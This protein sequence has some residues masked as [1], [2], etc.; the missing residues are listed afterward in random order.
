MATSGRWRVN[1]EW[2]PVNR[3]RS[4]RRRGPGPGASLSQS[5]HWCRS[6]PRV[7]RSGDGPRRRA[8]D[9]R[10][11]ACV[12]GR[13]AERRPAQS[14][15]AGRARRRPTSALSPS[16]RHSRPRMRRWR[17]HWSFA[18][19]SAARGRTRPTLAPGPRR[20]A[21]SSSIPPWRRGMSRSATCGCSGT[22]TG[23]ARRRAIAARS[24]SIQTPRVRTS[25]MRCSSTRWAALTRPCAKARP[26]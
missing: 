24:R 20:S 25:S 4:R 18:A 2:P 26:R 15:I 14:R 5:S 12:R 22:A 16:I 1:A 13:A 19:C 3:R 11:G 23:V 21:P 17:T 6:S 9:R 10:S 8:A 7:G